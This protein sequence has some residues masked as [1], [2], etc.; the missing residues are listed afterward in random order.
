M[1]FT[2][3]VTGLEALASELEK[4]VAAASTD[5]MRQATQGLKDDLRQQIVTAGLG[6]R[7]SNTWRSEVYPQGRVSVTPA[8]YVY[9][10]APAIA[11]SYARGV[12]IRPLAG[13]RYLWIPTANVPRSRG[14]RGQKRAA[15][16]EDVLAQFGGEFL[17]RRGKRGS[18]LAFL[19]IDGGRRRR[20][21]K[22]TLMFVLVR[23]VTKPRLLNLQAAADAAA[24]DFAIRLS[25]GLEA[26]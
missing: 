12:T 20:R 25:T 2:A 17:F 13:R 5:A 15:S 22:L 6:N 18:L 26:A 8:G 7:L 23:S 9:S 19:K 24:D 16:P 21:G 14:R 4:A 11:D 1:R 10:R 3:T